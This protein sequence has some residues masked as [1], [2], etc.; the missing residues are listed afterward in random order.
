MEKKMKMWIAV[1]VVVMVVVSGVFYIIILPKDNPKYNCEIK[2][3][4]SENETAWI[5]NV[6]AIEIKR[7][8]KK[9][10]RVDLLDD[11]FT[12]IKIYRDN[13]SWSIPLSYFEYKPDDF[14]ITFIDQNNNSYLNIGDKL[15]FNKS[16]GTNYIPMEGDR[17]SIFSSAYHHIY[18]E[19]NN[20][21]LP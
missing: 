21:K 14:G 4:I 15:I 20:I 6:T 10:N 16:G 17:I 5:V 7:E 2:I 13:N 18:V 9:V 19:S 11:G 1:G 12:E 8:G 3:N